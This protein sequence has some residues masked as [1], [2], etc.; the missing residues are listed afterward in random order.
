MLT[1]QVQVE[2]F[3]KFNCLKNASF[4]PTSERKLNIKSMVDDETIEFV[5]SNTHHK[6]SGISKKTSGHGVHL[7]QETIRAYNGQMIITP[8]DGKYET[9][10]TLPNY[11]HQLGHEINKFYK[12][13]LKDQNMTSA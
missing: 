9:A 2:S 11:W 10:V 7:I 13:R 12:K 6:Q 1:R 5:F 8:D 4:I 3:I